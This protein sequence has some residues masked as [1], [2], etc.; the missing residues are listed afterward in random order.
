MMNH[1]M[2]K[3]DFREG[4]DNRFSRYKDYFAGV[5]GEITGM[6]FLRTIHK[7]HRIKTR[8]KIVPSIVGRRRRRREIYERSAAG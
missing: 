1:D 4:N 2:A 3:A 6:M 5:V 7:P 8:T